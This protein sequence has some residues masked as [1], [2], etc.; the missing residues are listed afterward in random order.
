MQTLYEIAENYRELL[1]AIDAGEIPE[2]AIADTL[3]GAGGELNA[4]LDA[5]TTFIK[6]L[7]AESD[8][9]K[10]QADALTE[11]R[12]AKESKADRL[13][14]YILACMKLAGKNKW[15]NDRHELSVRKNPPRLVVADEEKLLKDS[16][17]AKISISL[18]KEALKEAVK[19]G[20][21]IEGAS[22]EASERLQIK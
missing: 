11:R 3:E 22:I 21:K 1:E 9:I 18:N 14:E 4:K 20:E 17:F 2:E 10:T 8:A 19:N 7:R 12:K 13:T 16:R 6:T 15:E 5:V